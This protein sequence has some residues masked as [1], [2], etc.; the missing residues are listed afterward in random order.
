[1]RQQLIVLIILAVLVGFEAFSQE[2]MNPRAYSFGGSCSSQGSWTADALAA[3]QNLMSVT[4]QLKNAPGCN[5]L[6]KSV[7][8]Y[9]TNLNEQMK[10]VSANEKAGNQLSRLKDESL[11]LR[12]F[13]TYTPAFRESVLK[14]ILNNTVESAITSSSYAV[15]TQ[16]QAAQNLM[17]V[18][19][20][21]NMAT[22]R[23]MDLVNNLMDS[24]LKES[25]CLSSPN[26]MG[27]L[28]SSLVT[29]SSAFVGSGQD[30]FGSKVATTLNKLSMF[31]RDAKFA[32][33]LK[34]LNKTQFRNSVSCLLEVTSESYC[35]TLDAS[36]LFK[37]QM[38]KYQIISDKQNNLVLSEKKVLS[39]I[40]KG[41]L[42]GYY[43]LT[44]QLPIVTS[45]LE[46]VQRG[47]DPQLK[48]DAQF[49]NDIINTTAKF[50]TRVNDVQAILNSE[51][52]T[53]LSLNGENAQRNQQLKII[54]LLTDA[55][56][57]GSFRNDDGNV[58]FFTISLTKMQIPFYLMDMETP[59]AVLGKGKTEYMQPADDWMQANINDIPTLK[60]KPVQ[61][62]QKVHEKL[63]SLIENA[64]DSAIAYYNE[65]F[66]YD[67]AA[68]FVDSLTG[69]RYNV[70]DALTNIKT[71][72]ID[73]QTRIENDPDIDSTPTP[74][75]ED[76][77]KRINAVL[78]HYDNMKNISIAFNKAKGNHA[79]RVQQA[80]AAEIEYKNL[81][82]EV[83]NQ[84]M[85]FKARS[86]F[87]ANRMSGFIK[88]DFQ[89]ML[90]TN[91]D[92]S[93]YVKD[94]F[95]ATG[96][97]AFERMKQM[98]SANPKDIMTDISNALVTQKENLLALEMLLKNNFLANISYLKLISENKR[99]DDEMIS[100]DSRK[101]AWKDYWQEFPM[102]TGSVPGY[103]L[104]ALIKP[105][106]YYF[107][108]YR[109]NP[110]RYPRTLGTGY[111]SNKTRAFVDTE[112]HSAKRLYQLYCIQSL[113]FTD[114]VPFRNLCKGAELESPFL[115]DIQNTPKEYKLRQT[116]NVNYDQKLSAFVTPQ[117]HDYS[118][119]HSERICALRDF[120]RSNLV[121]Y[122]TL[123]LQTK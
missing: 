112:E 22:T 89:T 14:L 94:I 31:M 121:L 52:K 88:I 45:W 61:F 19:K 100:T 118:R 71:Y 106:D 20:R 34:Q 26:T 80:D 90:K 70:R 5:S 122:L 95:Y 24:A 85:V 109:G 38:S 55:L 113:A 15:R 39:G 77:I 110:D 67:Q 16:G 92:I 40:S 43:I 30:S 41:P 46:K 7:E 6:A 114:W 99:P 66:I 27:P 47:I 68:L 87:I 10:D 91:K 86:G 32:N 107:S 105:F 111:G 44:Q 116:L 3:T 120:G 81:I 76:T 75:I 21:L 33:V 13:M 58:N 42:Q 108:F 103:F 104:E 78:A 98:S 54:M 119:N 69:M 115:Q 4:E 65:W 11:S 35:N 60:M 73:L 93:K 57:N 9:L 29:I 49:K 59:A 8:S 12:Q 56:S 102:T 79:V 123:G 25:Q 62:I 53:L 48:T 74:E 1:M 50:Y 101:R 84:F 83:Y 64:Q 117:N 97:A 63:D 23:S 37:E 82:K 72:L 2:E 18:G 51:S 36:R 28:L 96:D 17:S